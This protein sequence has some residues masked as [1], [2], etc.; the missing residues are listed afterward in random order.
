[1]SDAADK[2]DIQDVHPEVPAAEPIQEAVTPPVEP[3]KEASPAPPNQVQQ[4]IPND[5]VPR[6]RL[7]EEVQKR[8]E[9]ES[10]MAPQQPQVDTDPRPKA[11]TYDDYNA[12]LAE[13]AAWNGRHAA[14]QEFTRLRQGEQAQTQQQQVQQRAEQAL[15]TWSAKI[16][17][18]A[19]RDPARH[20]RALE[21]LGALPVELG[22]S[23]LEDANAK[24]L[25]EFFTDNPNEAYRISRL[26]PM[27]AGRELERLGTKLTAASGGPQKKPS[28][29]VPNLDPVGGGS[30]PGK[31]S[32][33]SSQSSEGDYVAATRRLPR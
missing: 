30:N 8:R 3:V 24:E 22:L 18:M 15:Q 12:Y 33:Y 9:L 26:A 31:K 5:Y 25:T 14:R 21:T 13:D 6:W 28:A 11:D 19:T 2:L 7:N 4:P 27:M 29:Q 17:D 32:P 1:M 10:R 16:G 23:V 20:A